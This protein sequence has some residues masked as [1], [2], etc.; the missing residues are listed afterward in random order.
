MNIQLQLVTWNSFPYLK[1]FFEALSK[2]SLTPCS[3]ICVDNNSTDGTKAFLSK[4][5]KIKTFFLQTNTGFSHGHNVGFTEAQKNPN[6]D[7]ILICNPDVILAPNAI[8]ILTDTLE[9][10]MHAGTVSGVLLRPHPL[11]ETSKMSIVDSAGIQK[12]FGF[13]FINRGEGQK[14]KKRFFGTTEVFANSGACMLIPRKALL[15]ISAKKTFLEFFDESFLAYKEDIDVGWRMQKHGYVNVCTSEVIGFHERNV[16]KT[17][18]YL[19]KSPHVVDLSYRNHIRLLKKNYRFLD[20]PLDIL[21]ILYY[22]IIKTLF[23][24][25]VHPSFFLKKQA[26]PPL[27]QE[28]ESLNNNYNVR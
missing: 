26:V 20:S 27:K 6:I 17:F 21:G 8:Q 28:N 7:A 3:V 9:K 2:Q 24:L 15:A 19:G 13:R 11:T 1:S 14:F 10:N 4:Q 25:V 12:K 23:L 22:L 16:K 5:V 18:G